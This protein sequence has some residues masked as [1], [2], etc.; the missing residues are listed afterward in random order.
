MARLAEH[1][2][3]AGTHW[4]SIAGTDPEVAASL[5]QGNLAVV[6]GRGAQAVAQ[7]AR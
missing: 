2:R 7:I 1:C 4:R 6:V 5:I 3:K